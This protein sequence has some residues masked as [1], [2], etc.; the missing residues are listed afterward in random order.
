MPKSVVIYSKRDGIYIG[1]ALGLGF[2]SNIDPVGQLSACTFESES[3]AREYISECKN[4]FNQS[5]LQFIEV[6]PDEG[7]YATVVA[8][9]K[10]GLPGWVIN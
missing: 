5:D 3:I 9:V 1:S 2:W 7:R 6:E 4:S 10:A 8:C